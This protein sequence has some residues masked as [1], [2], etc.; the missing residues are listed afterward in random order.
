MYV[1]HRALGATKLIDLHGVFLSLILLS[2]QAAQEIISLMPIKDN[3]LV[4][5]VRCVIEFVAVAAG[6]GP[7]QIVC[8]DKND[9]RR[10]CDWGGGRK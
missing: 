3:S 8:Q 2:M 10:F 7:P 4:L 9:V 1:H 5:V 6:L